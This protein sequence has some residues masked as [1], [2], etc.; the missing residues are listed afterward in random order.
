MCKLKK[1]VILSTG[2]SDLR[3]IIEVSKFLKKF[4]NQFAIMNC[5][6]EYPPI[7]EDINIGFIE[8]LKKKLPN[9]VI[10][11]SDHTNTIYTSLAAVARGAKIIE[12]HFILHKDIG[13]PDADF[14]LDFSEFKEMV[15]KVRQTEKL[16]GDISYD[17][18]E[19]VKKNRK[20]ARSLFI[21]KDV[22]KGSLLTKENIRSIRPGNGLHPKYYK[23]II[24][25]KFTQDVARGTPLSV[26]L[27]I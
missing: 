13:G 10:G 1:P 12:K 6:S 27:F 11:H 8:V 17:V 22:K 23:E 9:F 21:V 5:T 15:D 25:K 14:S 4:K 7:Y 20:F 2:M 19:K 16:L 26:D 3:E 24:G 18:S